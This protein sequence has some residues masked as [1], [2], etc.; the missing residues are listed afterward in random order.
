MGKL[1]LRTKEGAVD[2]GE[3]AKEN[4]S[5]LHSSQECHNK[6]KR[7]AKDKAYIQATKRSGKR[8]KIRDHPS[9]HPGEVGRKR[10]EREGMCIHT[11][12]KAHFAG[13]L[14]KT[15]GHRG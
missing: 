13:T 7:G 5:F 1:C 12:S 15:E 3:D 14:G 9:C 2:G 6:K 11:I 8:K 10:V 4:N